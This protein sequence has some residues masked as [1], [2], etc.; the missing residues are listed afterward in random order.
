M[1]KPLRLMSVVVHLRGCK[2]DSKRM[3]NEKRE[4]TEQGL[5]Q[6]FCTLIKKTHY[7]GNIETVHQWSPV[8]C[9]CHNPLLNAPPGIP[10]PTI[11]A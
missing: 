2:S 9:L 4:T 7:D 6:T 5:K 8:L 3:N 11:T 10:T 1:K